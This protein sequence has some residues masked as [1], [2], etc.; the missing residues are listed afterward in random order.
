MSDLLL[1]TVQSIALSIPWRPKPDKHGVDQLITLEGSNKHLL[2][3]N[4]FKDQEGRIMCVWTSVPHLGQ[5]WGEILMFG[6]VVGCG[7]T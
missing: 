4:M 5:S 2:Y 3:E 1:F 6:S 7:S